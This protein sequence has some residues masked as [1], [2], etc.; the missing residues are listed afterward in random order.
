MFS[1]TRSDINL[2]VG[3]KGISFRECKSKYKITLSEHQI[4]AAGT[5]GEDACLSHSGG[6]IMEYVQD[7]RLKYHYLVGVLHDGI[8]CSRFSVYTRV[9]AY[10]EWIFDNLK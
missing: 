5:N 2:S 6:P 10:M 1:G 7:S 9:D 4:C 8:Q 3:A